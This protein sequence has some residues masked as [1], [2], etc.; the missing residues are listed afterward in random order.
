VVVTPDGLI[1]ALQGKLQ[2]EAEKAVQAALAKQMNDRIQDA[3][4]SIDEARQL[5][6]REMQELVPTR[7]EEMKLSLKEESAGEIA[8]QWKTQINAYRRQVEEMAQGLEKQAGELRRELAN[9]AQDYTE[10]MTREIGSQIPTRLNEAICRATSDFEGATALVVD[11]RYEQLFEN[12]QIATQEALLK[13]NARSAEVQALAQ[14][15][16]NSGMEEFRLETE[17]HMKMALTETKERAVSALSSLDAESRA[18]FD[19]RRRALEAEVS[20]LAERA[21]EEFRKGMTAFLQSCLAT[22][23]GAVDEHSKT[24]L[25]GL[26]KR[27]GEI[28]EPA[29]E[30]SAHGAES[31]IVRDASNGL[32][33]H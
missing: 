15:A 8:A 32:L 31:E 6:V 7:I 9:A 2:Q 21:T 22:A 11:R 25:N 20:R 23:M 10:K 4:R 5:S 1:S 26:L 30:K 12:V 29:R 18:T 27:N 16:V 28:L 3:L 24:T 14:S 17:R 19:A 13:L 33:A